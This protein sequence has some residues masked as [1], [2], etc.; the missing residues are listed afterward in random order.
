MTGERMTEKTFDF[1][2]IELKFANEFIRKY[3]RHNKAVVG[4]KFQIGITYN[5]QLIG[6]GIAGRPIARML[7]DGKTIEILRVCVLEHYPNACS[8]LYGR[9]REICK[10]MGYRR[11]ITYTL[12]RESQSSLKAIGAE[13][14][15]EV[16]PQSWNRIKRPR[17]SQEV[18]NEPKLRWDL[19]K[20][21]E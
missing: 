11:I 12:K 19:I 2:P 7:A 16:K 10:Q 1:I 9:L 13:I 8:K 6:V 5:N 15:S 17:S 21:R 4:A 14:S 20:V 3:H 18:Y